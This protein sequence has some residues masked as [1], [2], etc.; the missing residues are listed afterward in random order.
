MIRSSSG[1][2]MM[3]RAFARLFVVALP[4]LCAA[5]GQS[6]GGG[7][8]SAGGTTTGG[9]GGTTTGGAGGSTTGECKSDADCQFG[10]PCLPVTPGGYKVCGSFPPEAT[11]CDPSDPSG[12]MCCK[13]ADCA[14]G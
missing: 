1:G 3:L 9:A 14:E 11:E 2:R 12:L 10:G 7:S 13:S 4:V 8:S 6:G 5:C